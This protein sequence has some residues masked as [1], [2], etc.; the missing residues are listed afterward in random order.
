MAS[1]KN[2]SLGGILSSLTLILLYLT[3]ILPTS[4]LFLLF[5]CSLFTAVIVIE[6]GT[7]NGWLFYLVTSMAGFLLIPDK[8]IAVL[9]IFLFGIYGLLKA[10][11]EKNSKAKFLEYIAKLILY[12]ILLFIMY[13]VAKLFIGSI[14]IALPYPMWAV[15][16]GLQVAFIIYDYAF[17]IFISYY[18]KHI[19]GKI[20]KG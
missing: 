19:K 8:A 2:I 4:R 15:F 9:Y 12:N 13:Y 18:Y 7:K 3:S 20:N 16:I 5:V 6:T 11:V 10:Y 17:T 14:N 1:S